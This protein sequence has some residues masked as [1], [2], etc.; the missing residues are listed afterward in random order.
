MLFY[1]IAIDYFSAPHPLL[2][3]LFAEITAN[4]PSSCEDVDTLSEYNTDTYY[5]IMARPRYEP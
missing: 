4:N 2:S 3:L 5:A 1:Q